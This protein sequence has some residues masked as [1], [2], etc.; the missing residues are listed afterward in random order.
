MN[1]TA[2]ES[3]PAPTHGGV[4]LPGL[5]GLRAYL[6]FWVIAFHIIAGLVIDKFPV[7][8]LL[9]PA[10]L[11][12]ANAGMWGVDGFFILSG[13]VLSHAY[14]RSMSTG[15]DLHGTLD[16]LGNR[17]ARI[18]PAHFAVLAGYGLVKLAGLSFLYESCGSPYQPVACERF[19]IEA[20][21]RHLTLI[22][23][24][25]WNPPLTWN[26]PA[27]SISSEW[28]A[29]L[30]FPLLIIAARRLH[31]A[32]AALALATVALLA[33]LGT[34]YL[35]GFHPFGEEP[36]AGLIRICGEFVCGVSLY[37][38]YHTP[39]Y[40][41]LPWHWIGSI[42]AVLVLSNVF[43]QVQWLLPFVMALIVLSAAQPRGPLSRLLSTRPMVWL[44]NVSYSLYMVHLLVLELLGILFPEPP[45]PPEQMGPLD[46]LGTI[47]FMVT[48]CV[49]GATALYYLVE[50][51][52]RVRVKSLVT[53]ALGQRS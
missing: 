4:A 9:P 50:E 13:F 24:W 44:G 28:F 37:R 1:P 32:G 38:F 33:M 49:V 6:A 52:A 25:G 36:E 35:H 51:P 27:W 7:D 17:L 20:L 53:R 21:F 19:G 48:L 26:P 10:A 22:S 42:A 2:P 15:F 46:V 14:G 16:F 40:A 23:S 31:T 11:G 12:F 43:G 47:I 41:R 30:C 39:L 3:H 29:Y 5:T 8:S 45:T 18:Y 34:L